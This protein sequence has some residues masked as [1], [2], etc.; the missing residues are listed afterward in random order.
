MTITE[1]I[2]EKLKALPQDKQQEVL[3]FLE[4]ICETGP[5]AQQNT[6]LGLWSKYGIDLSPEE[7][8]EAR[9]GLW[10]SF[11]SDKRA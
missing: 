11:A 7:I 3:V 2:A 1:L 8:D 4:S 9:I 10:S 6:L 5:S